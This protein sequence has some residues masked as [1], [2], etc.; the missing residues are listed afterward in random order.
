MVPPLRG[1][2]NCSRGPGRQAGAGHGPG[3]RRRH[4]EVGVGSLALGSALAPFLREPAQGGGRKKE[5][6]AANLQWRMRPTSQVGT[7]KRKTWRLE[8]ASAGR[9]WSDKK[10]G[11]PSGLR[12][13]RV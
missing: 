9:W 6:R 12:R 7:R 11:N 3:T 8:C 2:E 4:P 10:P 5:L 13:V 1:R